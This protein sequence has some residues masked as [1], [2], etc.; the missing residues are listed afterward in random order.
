MMTDFEKFA[1]E[2]NLDDEERIVCA[3]KLAQIRA[4]ETIKRLIDA[5]KVTVDDL[6]R[7]FDI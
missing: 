2:M 6:L 5:R 1:I 3:M 4:T 7:V